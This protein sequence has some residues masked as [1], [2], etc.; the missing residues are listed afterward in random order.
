MMEYTGENLTILNEFQKMG[1][2]VSIDDFGTGYSSMNYLKSFS[3]D[4]IKIDKSFIDN[5]PSDSSNREVSMAIIALSHSLG[6]Q[7]IAEGIEDKAQEDFLREQG[8]DY[9]QGYY[10]SRPLEGEALMSFIRNR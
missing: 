7:V 2:S 6:Y 8:C 9:G 4:K 5:L 10:F 1:C 3:L